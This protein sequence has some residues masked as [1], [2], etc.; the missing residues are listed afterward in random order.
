MSKKKVRTVQK[1]LGKKVQPDLRVSK[2]LE[3][4]KKT[5]GG[6]TIA[7]NSG[8]GVSTNLS[9]IGICFFF[10]LKSAALK[11]KNFNKNKI[12][13]TFVLIFVLLKQNEI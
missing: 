8:G 5:F 3:I 9:I 2:N 11:I 13:K 10:S 4:I 1:R 12:K 6:P 7:T